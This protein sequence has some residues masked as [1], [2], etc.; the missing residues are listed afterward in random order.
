MDDDKYMIHI[1]QNFTQSI[2]N[3]NQSFGTLSIL[4][5]EMNRKLDNIP[6]ED[7]FKELRLEWRSHLAESLDGLEVGDKFELVMKGMDSLFKDLRRD[8]AKYEELVEMMKNKMLKEMCV[9]MSKE[10]LQCKIDS[11]MKLKN[12]DYNFEE[13]KEK[14]DKNFQLLL[15]ILTGAGILIFAIFEVIKKFYFGM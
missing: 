7:L 15:K 6:G 11:E 14:K 8:M 9:E 1:I 5:G 12:L 10:E 2:N 3:L 13:K 4:L